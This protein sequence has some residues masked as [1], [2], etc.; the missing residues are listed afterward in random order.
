MRYIFGI[1]LIID[2][3]VIMFCSNSGV[4]IP[5]WI[6]QFLLD[7][8][9]LPFMTRIFRKRRTDRLFSFVWYSNHNLLDHLGGSGSKE[10]KVDLSFYEQLL[11]VVFFNFLWAKKKNYFVWKHCS[12]C[13]EKLDRKKVK[14]FFLGG[15]DFFFGKNQVFFRAK[16]ATVSR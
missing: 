4:Q 15:E 6:S 13:T 2:H 5:A 14:K 7:L 11:G 12:V 9:G 10:K 1:Y 3:G 8:F 16:N